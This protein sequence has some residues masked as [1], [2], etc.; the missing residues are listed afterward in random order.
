MLKSWPHRL[1]AVLSRAIQS[2][3]VTSS[4]SQPNSTSKP[5]GVAELEAQHVAVE[6]QRLHVVLRG[7]DDVAETL[8]LGDELV[9]V[10]A[11]DAAVF[12]GC[13]VENLE[14]V[15]GRVVEPDHLVDAAFG[16][17]GR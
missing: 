6:V 8:L 15:A 3:S 5:P 4:P 16:Q 14:G 1:T 10:R 17:L 11:D 7:Q 12:E 9:A 13:T 2:S